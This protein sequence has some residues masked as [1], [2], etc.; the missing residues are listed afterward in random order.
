MKDSEFIELLNLYLDHEIAAAD[1]A[2][3]EAEVL[4]SPARR[5]MYQDYCRMQKACKILAQDFV[6]EAAPA[7]RHVV[8]F[9]SARRPRRASWV[10]AGAFAA[11]AACVTVVFVNFNRET[12]G[13]AKTSNS[14]LVREEAV[15]IP[16]AQPATN[17]SRSLPAVVKVAAPAHDNRLVPVRAFSLAST[18][19]AVPLTERFVSSADPAAPQ[20][21]WMNA[22]QLAP[23][24]RPALEDFRFDRTAVQAPVPNRT[25]IKYNGE[26]LPLVAPRWQKR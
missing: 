3:L 7:P 15:A 21:A 20:F 19:D 18:S 6:E 16:T 14:T 22:V 4:K 1:A 26:Q 23:I 5:G 13:S 25:L 10:A 11:A 2:R 12:P 17:A 8:A 9:E 24:Q